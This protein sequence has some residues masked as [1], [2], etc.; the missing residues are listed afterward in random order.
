VSTRRLAERLAAPT[1]HFGG[2]CH[3]SKFEY[4]VVISLLIFF[5]DDEYIKKVV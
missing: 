1:G 4:I 5:L 3:L 2:T